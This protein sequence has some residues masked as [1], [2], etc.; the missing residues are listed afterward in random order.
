V[1]PNGPV[2]TDLDVEQLLAVDELRSRG[3]DGAGVKVAIVD[4]GFN[5]TYLRNRGKTPAFDSELTSGPTP[6]QP[7]GAM[8]LH[9]ATMCADAVCLAAPNCTLVDHAVLTSRAQGG[10]VM[11]GLLSDAVASYAFLLS[12]LTKAPVPFRGDHTPRTLVISNSWGMF[13]PSWDFPVG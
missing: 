9:P 3:L 4:T 5:R 11:D 2:G 12:Y 1:C 13:H 6:N 10:S 7:L 8:P